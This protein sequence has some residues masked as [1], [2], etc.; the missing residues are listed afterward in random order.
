MK[1]LL[2]GARL[3]G[4][5][6]ALCALTL[7]V[8]LYGPAVPA[9]TGPEVIVKVTIEH[10]VTLAENCEETLTNTECDFYTRIQIDGDT[11]QSDTIDND[12]NI[13]PNWEFSK[14]VPVSQGTVPIAIQLWD[15]DTLDNDHFDFTHGE[16]PPG[17]DLSLTVNLAPCS[18]GS[19]ALIRP[20]GAG[21][22]QDSYTGA[23]DVTLVSDQVTSPRTLVAFKVEV[24]DPPYGPD[25]GIRCIHSP[26]WPQPGEAVRITAE[27]LDGYTSPKAVDN[28]Q[29]Y[30]DNTSTP[31]ASTAVNGPAGGSSISRT[32]VP[33]GP[34]SFFYG[35]RAVDGSTPPV[36]T[37][38]RS[39]QIGQPAHGRAVPIMNTG[40]SSNRI[41][42]VFVADV[43]DFLGPDD[44]EFLGDV[45]QAIRE[46]YNG[47]ALRN[48]GRLFLENQ[49]TVNYWIALDTAQVASASS[50]TADNVKPP[51]NWAEDY[52]F[53]N[54]GALLHHG[55][56]LR[57]CAEIGKRVFTTNIKN[58]YGW[59]VKIFM[60]ET[61][62]MPFGLSDEYCCDGGY[63]SGKVYRNVYAF[64][65]VCQNDAL[66][67]LAQDTCQQIAD[68]STGESVNYYRLDS[69]STL[70]NDLMVS[71]G[72]LTPRPADKR[73]IEWIFEKC[74]SAGCSGNP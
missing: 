22:D 48:A 17:H 37:G 51:A 35:C 36:F 9:A 65:K 12:N 42:I 33:Q 74:Y 69:A 7:P 46:G 16:N 15:S 39:V 66:A 41:D 52:T 55:Q 63:E 64:Q 54:A 49:E 38:W 5:W 20:E 56:A 29:I 19:N 59:G 6:R 71:S 8:T 70:D 43:P 30:V 61:G 53:A 4:V 73:R 31:V 11:Y 45:E 62:H 1:G 10:V 25:L 18:I 3:I 72:D 34:N 47:E 32:F 24:S 44:P 27:A 23:C 14:R 26:V 50:C 28:I 21:Y 57:D 2:Q 40:P 68:P 67:S 13:Y 60:H 58:A